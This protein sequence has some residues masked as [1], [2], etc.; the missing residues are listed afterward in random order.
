MVFLELFSGSKI[1]SKIF[2]QNGWNVFNVDWKEESDLNIDILNLK[3]IDIIKLCGSTPDIIWASPEC[4]CF[5]LAARDT[6]LKKEKNGSYTPKT[7]KAEHDIKTI[8]HVLNLIKELNP[9]IWFIENPVGKLS[10]MNF[11]PNKYL[12]KVDFCMYGL[13]I[14]KQTHLWCNHSLNFWKCNHDKH[15]SWDEYKAKKNHLERAILPIVFCETICWYCKW[16][17][18]QIELKKIHEQL[19]DELNE[20]TNIKEILKTQNDKTRNPNGWK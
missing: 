7:P 9:K 15:L 5:S 1:M 6:H 19:K 18:N 17:F 2:K 13:P 20:L 4:T 8:K 3:T 14:K 10:K 16:I 12:Q 11:M